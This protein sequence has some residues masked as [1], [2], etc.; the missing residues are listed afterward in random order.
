[1]GAG[2]GAG[3]GGGGGLEVHP[4]KFGLDP[5]VMTA[6]PQGSDVNNWYRR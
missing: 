2:L 4:R 5:P 3:L 1:M 6:G